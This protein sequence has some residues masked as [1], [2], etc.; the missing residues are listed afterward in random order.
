MTAKALNKAQRNE[1]QKRHGM[2]IHT[3]GHFS[4]FSLLCFWYFLSVMLILRLGYN[5]S[6][7]SSGFLMECCSRKQAAFLDPKQSAT[8]N[9]PELPDNFWISPG[10]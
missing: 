3:T 8:A 7:A 6:L 9:K 1:W 4:A 10:Q 5:C 2:Y